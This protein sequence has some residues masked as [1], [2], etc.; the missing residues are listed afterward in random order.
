MTRAETAPS[1]VLTRRRTTKLLLALLAVLVSCFFAFP[2]FWALVTSL[3]PP[4]KAFNDAV[5]PFLQFDPTLDNWSAEFADR[6][7]LISKGLTNS[8]I[9]ATLS[10][11]ICVTLGTFAG[12][13][14][15]RATLSEKR[16][17]T[18]TDWLLSQRLLLPVVVVIPYLLTFRALGLVDN[19]VALVVAYSVFNLPLAVLVMKDFFADVPV[20]LEEAAMTDGAS[21]FQAFRTV[22][23]PV[24]VPGMVATFVLVAAFAW[25][26][27]L[28]ALALTYNNA[29]TMPV[30]IIGAEST[31]GVEFWYIAVRSL[32]AMVPPV[33]LV[34][35]VQRYIVR[36]LSMGAVKG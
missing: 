6:G 30:A 11:L 3:K 25:N 35:F 14:L 2:F 7:D 18:V 32:I 8:T 28:F 4:E 19:I 22:V 1:I 33:L 26:E 20:D 13:S 27:F 15:A 34:M 29:T 17:R 12:Y 16:T 24:V 9:A 36:G 5:I 23:L 21:Q 10:A 31:R